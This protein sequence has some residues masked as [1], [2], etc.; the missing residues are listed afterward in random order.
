[1]SHVSYITYHA[2][3]IKYQTVSCPSV[4]Y[5]V[6]VV[7]VISIS[8]WVVAICH[9]SILMSWCRLK[10]N[11]YGYRISRIDKILLILLSWGYHLYSFYHYNDH[12]PLPYSNTIDYGLQESK[13][14]LQGNIV[15]VDEY[16]ISI[17][18]FTHAQNSRFLL[19]I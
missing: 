3:Y 13:L 6:Y 11:L 7:L 19:D 5:H 4:K 18:G 10:Y 12:L 2:N 9:M 8:C 1:M 15:V 16:Q 14:R 17:V